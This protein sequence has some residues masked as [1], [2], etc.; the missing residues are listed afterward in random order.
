MGRLWIATAGISAVLSLS[1]LGGH[2]ASSPARAAAADTPTLF[3]WEEYV[4]ASFLAEYRQSFR[5]TPKTS[6]F[7]DEDEA[8]AKMRAGFKPDVMGPCYYEFPRWQEAQ[9]LR[10]IDTTK[11]KNWNKISPAVRNL[12]GISAGPDKVW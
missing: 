12:P 3:Q 9:L 5:E 6:I 4:D 8:F 2:P 10:T 11:L 7:A 1:L